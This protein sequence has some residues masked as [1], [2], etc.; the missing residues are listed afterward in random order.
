MSQSVTATN[1]SPD[2]ISNLFEER[3]RQPLQEDSSPSSEQ[4]RA[5][6]ALS[7]L[8]PSELPEPSNRELETEAAKVDDQA[9][10]SA[11]LK[12]LQAEL[13]KT[14][15]AFT[16]TQKYG[17]SNARKIKAAQKKARMLAEN[18]SLSDDEA[19]GLLELLENEYEE[20]EETS[21]DPLKNILKI[22]N[23]ELENFAK[24]SEDPLLNEKIKSFDLLLS[25]ADEKEVQE[26]LEELNDSIDDPIKLAKKM[27][28]LGDQFHKNSGSEIIATGSIANYIKK[29]KEEIQKLNKNIDKLTKKV[30]EYEDYDQPRQRI[31]EVGES[32]DASAEKR[33][34][35]ESLFSDRDRQD[36]A[37][38]KRLA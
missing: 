5:A 30:S 11:D 10:D 15:K 17:H 26:I 16:D 29:Q 36:Q 9:I 7:S 14:K 32:K 35:I 4:K 33:T 27:L 37:K 2:T 34:S 19:Q 22:A 38:Q 8:E 18:G 13:E 1:P 31:S 12:T 24:Y 3:D 20:V 21:S 23:R 25:F 6:P 28:S